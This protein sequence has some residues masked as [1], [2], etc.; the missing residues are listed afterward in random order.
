MKQGIYAP[1]TSEKTTFRGLEFWI[2]PPPAKPRRGR[3]EVDSEAVTVRLSRETLTALDEARAEFSER[4]PPSRAEVVR[5]ALIEW[6]EGR[7][8]RD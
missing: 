7:K 5:T 8:P 4:F 1:L 2:D 6:L 3:P